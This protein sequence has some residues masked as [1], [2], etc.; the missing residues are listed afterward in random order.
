GVAEPFSVSLSVSLWA[1]ILFAVPMLLWQAW[2]FL[3][4]ALDPAAERR[5]L[6]MAAFGLVLA[7]SGLAFGYGI[8]VPRAVHW[9]VAD[10]PGPLPAPDS[11]QQLLL[12]RRLGAPGRRCRVRAAARRARPRQPRR[13]HV[14]HFAAQPAARL[15]PRRD[16]RPRVAGAGSRDDG[17]GAPADVGA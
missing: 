1:G 9:L 16:S 3:A 8:L 12:V 11:G 5:I 14:G 2:S 15:L 6:A 4:P 10:G 13:A 17:A 7:A